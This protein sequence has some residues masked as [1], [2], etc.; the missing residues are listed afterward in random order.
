M[1]DLKLT[2]AGPVNL[3]ANVF[4]DHAK[5]FYSSSAKRDGRVTLL[6]GSMLEKPD[7][8]GW[9]YRDLEHLATMGYVERIGVRY[10]VSK[11]IVGS[12]S[13]TAAAVLGAGI[14]PNGYDEWKL[15]NGDS[16]NESGDR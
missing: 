12:T 13:G 4:I 2:P 11:P 8:N 3:I 15:A 1:T 10:K 5:G 14:K 16:I 9:I 6:P 7:Y